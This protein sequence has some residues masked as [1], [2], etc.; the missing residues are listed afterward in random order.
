MRAD[1]EMDRTD[2]PDDE[3][4]ALDEQERDEDDVD[5]DPA[6]D[7]DTDPPASGDGP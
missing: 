3:D 6:E 7:P 2:E 1:E 5:Y 4:V